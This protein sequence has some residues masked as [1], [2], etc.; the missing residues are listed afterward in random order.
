M[1]TSANT[2]PLK[3]KAISM[4]TLN[5]FLDTYSNGIPVTVK[6]DTL[7]VVTLCTGVLV[8]ALLV[9]LAKRFLS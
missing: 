2:D 5:N 6:V 9:M 7:S 4:N 1:T 3:R 8:T